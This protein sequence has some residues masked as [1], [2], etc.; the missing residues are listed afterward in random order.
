[1]TL[2]RSLFLVLI[3]LIFSSGNA[4]EIRETKVKAKV[5][6]FLE[7]ARITRKKTW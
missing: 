2:K 1:M 6:V 3:A 5:T 7:D 4:Q